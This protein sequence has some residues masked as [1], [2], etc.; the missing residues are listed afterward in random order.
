MSLAAELM[1]VVLCCMG[2]T[3]LIW[4]GQ[5]LAKEPV[6]WL[7]DLLSAVVVV[8]LAACLL[9]VATFVLGPK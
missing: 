4:L 6:S 3:V 9:A 1:L 8:G 7:R 2:A 5:L